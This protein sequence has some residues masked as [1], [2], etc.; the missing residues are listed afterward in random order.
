MPEF[1]SKSEALS[2]GMMVGIHTDNL[3]PR[4][5]ETGKFIPCRLNLDNLK[6]EQGRKSLDINR[7]MWIGGER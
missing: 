1:V 5:D 2:A 3:M 7:R 6:S 4:T